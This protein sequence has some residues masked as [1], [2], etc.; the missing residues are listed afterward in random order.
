MKTWL[1]PKNDGRYLNFLDRP[2]DIQHIGCL[3]HARPTFADIVKAQGKK[4]KPGSAH[5]GVAFFSKIY[6]IKKMCRDE[7]LTPEEIYQ[8]R[9]KHSKPVLEELKSWLVK[10]KQQVPPKTALGK[11]VTYTLNQW[12]RLIGYLEDGRLAPDNNAAEN[13]IRLL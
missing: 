12:H 8:R 4:A 13:S 2:K 11:A 7:H 6:K 9:L 3:V 5:K 1:W 10:K